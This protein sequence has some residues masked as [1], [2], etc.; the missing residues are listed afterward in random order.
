MMN[1]LS[2]QGNPQ[3]GEIMKFGLDCSG[4]FEAKARPDPQNANMRKAIIKTASVAAKG[5]ITNG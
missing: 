4:N 5:K 2:G 3:T 1:E